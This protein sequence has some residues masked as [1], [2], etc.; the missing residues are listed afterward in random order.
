MVAEPYDFYANLRYP[1]G[2]KLRPDVELYTVTEEGGGPKE[3]KRR[4]VNWWPRKGVDIIEVKQ[5]MPLRTW[6]W[7]DGPMDPAL[8]KQMPQPVLARWTSFQ[9]TRNNQDDNYMRSVYGWIHPPNTGDY[10][11]KVCGDDDATLYLSTD[12]NPTNKRRIAAQT[13]YAMPGQ[14]ERREGQV[15]LP[16]RLT[17]GKRYYIEAIQHDLEGGDHLEVGW[18]GPGVTFDVIDG[19][20]LADKD[21]TRGGI[22]Q[23]FMPLP[24]ATGRSQPFDAPKQFQA[25]LVGF[26]GIGNTMSKKY[27]G[28]DGGPIEPA[29]VLRLAD[30]RKR[31]FARNSFA[32]AD[33]AY[34]MDIYVKE[35]ERI[36]AGLDQTP[37]VISPNVN[38]TFPNNA[39]PGQPGTMQV[40]SDHFVWVSGT[41][42]KSLWINDDEPEN[43]QWFRDGAVQCAEYY[44]ALEEYAGVLMPFWEKKI[45]HKYAITAGKNIRDGTTAVPGGAG[46]GYG[47]CS[48]GD[49]GG[50]QWSEGLFHEWGHGAP[51]PGGCIGGGEAAAD[52]HAAIADPATLKGMHHITR[53][54]RNLWNGMDGYGFT[55]FYLLAG[56]DPNWGYAW[57]V[58]IPRAEGE[59]CEL[60]TLARVGQQRGLFKQGIRGV[61]DMVGDYGARLTTFDFEMED[62]LQRE[63]F[64]PARNWLEPVDL[65]KRIYRIPCEEAAEPFGVNMCR[66]VADAGA[67]RITVDFRGR[68][69][70][71]SYSDWRA[72]IIA[73]AADGTRRYSPLWNKDEMSLKIETGDRCHWL[74]VAATPTALFMFGKTRDAALRTDRGKPPFLYSGRHA[75]RYPWEIQLK[76]ARP[77]TPRHK[78]VDIDDASFLRTL[79]DSVPAPH[80]TPEGKSFLTR[81]KLFEQYLAMCEAK[82][83]NTKQIMDAIFSAKTELQ[84]ELAR[85]TGGARHPNGGG[86]VQSTAQAAPTAYVGPNA[87]VL[88]Q[89]QVLD[90]A[91]IEDYAVVADSAVVANHARVSGQ[92]LVR[93][94]AELRGY[95]RAWTIAASA[96]EAPVVPL[97]PGATELDKFGLWANYAMDRADN[98]MLEDWYRYAYDADGGYGMN[99]VPVLNGYLYGEPAFVTDAN[100][101][102]F[103]FDGRRQWAEL[104]PRAADLGAMTI[105][106]T[107]KWEGQGEQT[108][109][110]LGSSEDYCLV[111]K[112]DSKGSPVLVATVGGKRVV[113]LTGKKPLPAGQWVRLRVESDGQRTSLWMDG[114]KAAETAGAF[115]PCDVFPGGAVKRNLLAVSRALNGHFQGV[116]D[117]V[118]VYHM[119][120]D[121]FSKL[122]PPVR[123]CP[124]RPSE[125]FVAAV[126]QQLAAARTD[127]AQVTA[128]TANP[129]KRYGVLDAQMKTRQKELTHRGRESRQEKTQQLYAPELEW[130]EH[131]SSA[132][133]SP[134]Y[135]T[136]YG[137]YMTK[138]V[139]AMMGGGEMR[140][141]I[142]FLEAL[143]KELARNDAWHTSVDWDT[144]IKWEKD[145]TLTDLP[146]LQKWMQRVGVGT[147]NR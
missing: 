33:K 46:G 21:G 31:M 52:T 59:F 58:C 105:D 99:L 112:T 116:I 6:T 117:N 139:N 129:M 18:E 24:P 127:E 142:A 64:A 75:L 55:T 70:P 95:A 106:L 104:C 39:K 10:V 141:N 3:Y 85:M 78:R 88:D 144:R 100:R 13:V 82:A 89:A 15:S 83:G 2:G 72:C 92:G 36:K 77:G 38:E 130:M 143:L 90:H 7:R 4:M 35:M 44:W 80:D 94:R 136:T 19:E 28:R 115:R 86:W 34:I 125:E 67:D 14:W 147:G 135:N 114:G 20:Y 74:S 5:G 41:Q 109:F 40:V 23:A 121:D 131:Y 22:T 140:E 42:G 91:I 56:D 61:G 65:A 107:L 53:P 84:T 9:S 110:D 45:Q 113:E 17:G 76:G 66:L 12:D 43:A 122:P 29:V 27:Q 96:G 137:R 62:I 25:H 133:S 134:H 71:D 26:R 128:M 119:V 1:V 101:R 93:K 118:V 126:R 73:V 32:A 108:I 16:V 50:G 79:K 69:D 146:L 145:G 60:D 123:D 132:S 51:G 54:W 49:A 11:F 98:T 63:R 48:I 57:S 103:R 8:V 47:G 97:R 30:G 68:H 81:L 111:L 37:Y 87:M 102:G 138:H 124:V 120:H